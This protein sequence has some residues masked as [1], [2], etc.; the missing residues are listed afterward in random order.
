MLSSDLDILKEHLRCKL[1]YIS[2]EHTTAA[3]LEL[4]TRSPKWNIKAD[5]SSHLFDCYERNKL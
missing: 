5:S 3:V 1:L 4:S 2:Q